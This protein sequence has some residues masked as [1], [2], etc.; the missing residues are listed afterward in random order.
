MA[1][2]VKLF[3]IK[4]SKKALRFIYLYCISNENGLTYE[5][6]RDLIFVTGLKFGPYDDQEHK[7]KW[8]A[9]QIIKNTKS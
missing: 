1:W 7:I 6:F 5:D 9:N 8:V 4:V 2:E 3:P